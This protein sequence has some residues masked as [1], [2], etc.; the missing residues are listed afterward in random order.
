MSL[1]AYERTT[2]ID[3]GGGA[4]DAPLTFDA[5]TVTG[6][7]PPPRLPSWWPWAAAAIA[8]AGL[9]YLTREGRGPLGVSG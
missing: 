4:G 6:N 5:I 8:I 1:G 3:P 9:W 2:T 7:P